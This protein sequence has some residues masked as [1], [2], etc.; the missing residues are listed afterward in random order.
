MKS[1]E[2][3]KYKVGDRVIIDYPYRQHSKEDGIFK[4]H[5]LCPYYSEGI[6]YA[7]SKFTTNKKSYIHKIEE[8]ELISIEELRRRKINGLL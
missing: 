4:I 8:K 3:F 6:F 5:Y 1:I 2:E 7:I